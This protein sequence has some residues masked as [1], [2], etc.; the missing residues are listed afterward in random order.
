[1]FSEICFGELTQAPR[2]HL[3]STR[4]IM[5]HQYPFD[6]YIDRECSQPL[7][8]KKHHAICNLRPHAWQGAQMFSQLGIGQR[9][10]RLEI[11]RPELTSR[12]VA[13]RFLARYPAYNCATPYPKL[14][15]VA[16]AEETY[17]L[18]E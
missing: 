6:P 9:R 7:V 8:R 10:P 3:L 12:A 14:V 16:T 1:M 18:G 15:Q 2:R 11:R 5:L 17:A 13:R 4:E